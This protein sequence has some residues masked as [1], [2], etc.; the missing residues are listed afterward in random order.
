MS[1]PMIPL[2]ALIAIVGGGAA[3]LW[4]DQLSKEEQQ[5]ADRIACGYAR[6][7]YGKAMK[8]LT[9]AEASHVTM[10]TERHFAN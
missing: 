3:L 10:L 8:E 6:D 7:V 9:E 1:T 2:L 5:R 4:Y